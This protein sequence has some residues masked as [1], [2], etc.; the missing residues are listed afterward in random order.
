[1]VVKFN[2]N[3]KYIKFTKN[4]FIKGVNKD[5]GQSRVQIIVR[6]AEHS[7]LRLKELES[8]RRFVRKFCK[9]KKGKLFIR[10]VPYQGLTYKSVGVRMGK[11]KGKKIKDYLCRIKP[12]K[13]LFEFEKNIKKLKLKTRTF[14]GRIYGVFFILKKKLSVGVNIFFI[15]K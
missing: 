14:I 15:N 4:F 12:G 11:G 6:C 7:F 8:S 10:V 2:R 1:M 9:K 3:V 13:V 5:W